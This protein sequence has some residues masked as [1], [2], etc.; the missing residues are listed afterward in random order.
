[1]KNLKLNLKKLVSLKGVSFI[2]VGSMALSMSG[3]SKKAECDISTYHAHRYMNEA[4]YVR[5]IDK[6]YLKYEGYERQEDSIDLTT[7]DKE[8]YHFMDKKNLMR[9]SDNV[10]VILANEENNTDYIEYRYAY[11]TLMPIVHTMKSGKSTITYVTYI[12][13]THYS[14]TR[15]QNHSRLTG[16]QRLCH[17]VY[18]AYK[19]EKDEKGRYVLIPSTEV[20]R[21]ED[22]MDEYPYISER[23]Y[24]VIDAKYGYD[25]DYED[26]PAEEDPN[27][28][29]EKDVP[30][31]DDHVEESK[32]LSKK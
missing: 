27:Y 2:L 25:L 17:Y 20:D 32:S 18:T 4:G 31:E 16:E 8:F 12:P 23:Y 29:I 3:C 24:K 9:I 22:V 21:I 13:I 26:G 10:D 5:Y 30:L 14:W 19:V 15:D 11:T 28:D 1:M 7:T 6:E